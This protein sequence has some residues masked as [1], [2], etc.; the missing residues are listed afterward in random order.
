MIKE[1]KTKEEFAEFRRI[2]IGNNVQT[3]EMINFYGTYI[4]SGK[5]CRTCPSS[6]GRAKREIS[7]EFS[8]METELNNKF[9]KK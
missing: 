2:V 5:I 7:E 9:K 4:S 3:H 1:I 6:V 8:R